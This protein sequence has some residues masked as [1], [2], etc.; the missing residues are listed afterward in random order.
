MR[1]TPKTRINDLIDTY[2]FLLEFLP[3]FNAKYEL[4]KNKTVRATVGL[5]ANLRKVAVIGGVAVN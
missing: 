5:M 3:A 2:P 4:L 1:I